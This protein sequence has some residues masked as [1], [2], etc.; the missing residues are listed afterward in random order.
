MSGCWN[1]NN[2]RSILSSLLPSLSR[3]FRDVAFFLSRRPCVLNALSRAFAENPE[4]NP[5]CSLANTYWNMCSQPAMWESLSSIRLHTAHRLFLLLLL[6]LLLLDP[7]PPSPP[8]PPLHPQPR[9]PDLSGHCRAPTASARCQ[10]AQPDTASARCQWALP[11]PYRMGGAIPAS[12]GLRG[13]S[14]ELS[15]SFRGFSGQSHL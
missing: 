4:K 9:A 10:W 3:T 15:R 6:L 11:H 12:Q 1:P 13:S 7:P 14:A 8:R 5:L 2:L